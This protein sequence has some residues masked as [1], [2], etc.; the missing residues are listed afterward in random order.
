METCVNACSFATRVLKKREFEKCCNL[1]ELASKVGAAE[2]LPADEASHFMKTDIEIPFFDNL[3]D[4]CFSVEEVKFA[5]V[6]AYLCY[7]IGTK[8]MSKP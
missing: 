6:D 5:V 8:L 3:K 1:M 7:T 2:T 4:V